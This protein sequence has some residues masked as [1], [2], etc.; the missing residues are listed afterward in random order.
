MVYSYFCEMKNNILYFLLTLLLVSCTQ[1][2][3]ISE[4]DAINGY[5]Q[6]SKAVDAKG[7]KKEY[8]INEVYDYFE[9]KNNKGFHK[10][11]VWQPTGTFLVNDLQDEVRV[12]TKDD[13]VFLTFSSK[14]GKHQD[15]LE[16]ISDNEMV[17][18]SEEGVSFYYSKV[19][20]NSKK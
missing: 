5:W 16:R 12:T 15:Q 19:V 2:A 9:L 10:K 1:K 8:P 7:N 20:L 11:V 18:V 6:I 14:F 3:T 4:I 17:L 13:T